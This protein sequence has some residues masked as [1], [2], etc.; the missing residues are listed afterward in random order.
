MSPGDI[1]RLLLQAQSLHKAGQS[2]R[3][4]R[5]VAEDVLGLPLPAL[6]DA[7]LD[8]GGV[9]GPL[10]RPLVLLATLMH[11]LGH[12]LAALMLGGSFAQ[13]QLWADGSG[14]ASRLKFGSVMSPERR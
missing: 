11:E 4:V 5:G 12:G 13:L 6:Q 7:E 3:A 10:A 14:V 1:R 8:P 2:A 9:V